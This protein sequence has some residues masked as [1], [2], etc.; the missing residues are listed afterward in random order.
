M[1]AGLAG[2]ASVEPGAGSPLLGMLIRHRT[3]N[4]TSATQSIILF[5]TLLAVQRVGHF[6]PLSLS[7]FNVGFPLAHSMSPSLSLRFCPYAAVL[8]FS[9]SF[10]ARSLWFLLVLSY[11]NNRKALCFPLPP[12]ST[13][14]V[15]EALSG[16]HTQT[17]T[18]PFTNTSPP[19]SLFGLACQVSGGGNISLPVFS[20][21]LRRV[22]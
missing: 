6:C 7:I 13:L 16:T 1:D 8:S 21:G 3:L 4:R 17:H 19:P 15:S 18:S 12:T 11:T 22:N 2:E 14:C 20:E 9:F 5:I 10:L